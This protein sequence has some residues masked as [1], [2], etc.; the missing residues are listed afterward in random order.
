[1]CTLEV[2]ATA[3]RRDGTWIIHLDD[4]LL[5]AC[6]GNINAGEYTEEVQQRIRELEAK[7][8]E[9]LDEWAEDFSD[10]VERWVDGLFGE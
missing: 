7:Q 3:E 6:M 2:T 5:N 9:K 4:A 1:M 10:N 8:N